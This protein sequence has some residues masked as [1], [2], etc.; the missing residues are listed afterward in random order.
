MTRVDL[1]EGIAIHGG[2]TELFF[3]RCG[4]RTLD[5]PEDENIA[6]AEREPSSTL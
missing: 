1:N 4:L 3:S 6:G 2:S 5:L